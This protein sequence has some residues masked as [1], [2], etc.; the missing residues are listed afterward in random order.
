MKMPVPRQAMVLAAGLGKRMRPLTDHMPKPMI[1]VAG[2]SLVDRAIDRLEE[3]G[4]DKVVVNT[5]YK[6]RMLEDHLL[7]RAS[8][9]IVFSRE[10]EPLET[11]GGI[12]QALPHFADEPFFAVNGDIIWLDDSG[13]SA[14]ERLALQ[15]DDTLDALLLLHPVKSAIG[16]DGKGDF[17]VD[18]EGHLTRRKSEA[19][20]LFVYAGVQ[21]LHPRLFSGC[22][23]GAFSLNLLYDKMM[24][25]SPPRIRG[26]I[27]NGRWLHVGDVN[28][29]KLAESCLLSD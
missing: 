26:I 17:E 23:R 27:H 3:A 10:S 7:R 1:E 14:L 22:P 21:L 19:K 2:R 9:Q 15:W 18:A 6:A 5:S 20:A 4:V 12:A 13:L 24:L 16:Y 11:G 28:G 25:A 29:L 8:P